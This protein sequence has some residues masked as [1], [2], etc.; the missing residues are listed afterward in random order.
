MLR[1]EQPCWVRTRLVRTTPCAQTGPATVWRKRVSTRRAS[2]RDPRGRAGGRSAFYG[3]HPSTARPRAPA[4]WTSCVSFG[5]NV[6]SAVRG[7]A[8]CANVAVARDR[9]KPG[10]GGISGGWHFASSRV[11]LS[12]RSASKPMQCVAPCTSTTQCR[13]L[14][15]GTTRGCCGGYTGTVSTFHLDTSHYLDCPET[16]VVSNKFTYRPVWLPLPVKWIVVSTALRSPLACHVRA[17]G[18]AEQAFGGLE[19]A[20]GASPAPKPRPHEP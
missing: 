11:S 14:S 15:W 20:D 6:R 2:C 5:T 10:W 18:L 3:S 4:A 19:A 9:Q 16:V 13:S 12:G 17:H 8:G 1:V 7:V